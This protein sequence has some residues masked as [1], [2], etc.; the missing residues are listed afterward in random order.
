MNIKDTI[1]EDKKIP[2]FENEENK[3]KNIMTYD[4]IRY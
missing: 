1:K 4:L 2:L 3:S